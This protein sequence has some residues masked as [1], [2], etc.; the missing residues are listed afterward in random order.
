[1]LLKKSNVAHHLRGK[2]FRYNGK[3]GLKQWLV[4]KTKKGGDKIANF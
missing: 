1:M 2:P 3:I 4:V